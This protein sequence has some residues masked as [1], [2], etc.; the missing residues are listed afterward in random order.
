MEITV[1]SPQACSSRSRAQSQPGVGTQSR[2]PVCA[3]GSR[4]CHCRHCCLSGTRSG[5]LDSRARMSHE[6]PNSCSEHL[7]TSERTFSTEMGKTKTPGVLSFSEPS[8]HVVSN[9]KTSCT[10]AL[11]TQHGKCYC[12]KECL[13]RR[14]S[15]I[16]SKVNL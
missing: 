6:F 10:K 9:A 13:L 7:A 4:S 1:H 11:L 8:D 12:P 15:E 2:S 14:T 5:K 16:D 3:Q